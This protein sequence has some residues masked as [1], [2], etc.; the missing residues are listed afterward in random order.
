MDGNILRLNI[1]TVN[2]EFMGLQFEGGKSSLMVVVVENEELEN[3][4]SQL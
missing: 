1:L 3:E 2:E 4:F